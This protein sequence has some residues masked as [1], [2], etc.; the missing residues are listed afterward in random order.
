MLC[1]SLQIM[2]FFYAGVERPGGEVK[3]NKKTK[4]KCPKLLEQKYFMHF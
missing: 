3:K 2:H 1:K 4:N